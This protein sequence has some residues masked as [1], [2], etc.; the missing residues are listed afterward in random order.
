MITAV[1]IYNQS[2]HF[3]T[4]YTPFSLLY[5]PY[6]NLNAHEINLDRT[7]YENYN[8]KRKKEIMPFYEQ[9][10]HK[11][12]EKGTKIL[13]KRNMGK[14]DT[15][16]VNELVVYFEKNKIRKSDPLYDKVNVSGVERNKVKG[17]RDKTK[18][19]ANIHVRKIKPSRKKFSS[20]QVRPPDDEPGPSSR[21]D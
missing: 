21:R 11:Q 19:N 10:Y 15:V 7:I 2:V 14:T 4:G 8:D 12:L 5:G 17:I 13:N 9:L 3:S 20:L 1:L 6:D 16:E 18:T